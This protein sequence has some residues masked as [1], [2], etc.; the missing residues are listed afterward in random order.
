M[1]TIA[2]HQKAPRTQKQIFLSIARNILK[3]GFEAKV[4][5]VEFT[6]EW[7]IKIN[8]NDLEELQEIYPEAS[9]SFNIK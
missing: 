4:V 2:N 6:E 9:F 3:F 1:I 8:Q 5:R 7:S